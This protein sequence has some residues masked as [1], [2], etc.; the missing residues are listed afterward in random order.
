MPAAA[1]TA[2][3]SLLV[4]QDANLLIDLHCGDLF[5]CVFSLATPWQI[6]IPDLIL[7]ELR[8]GTG[9]V[10]AALLPY[11]DS[12]RFVA[13]TLAGPQVAEVAQLYATQSGL[14]FEDYAAFV[15][16]RE[17]GAVLLT[18]DALLRRFAQTQQVAVHGTLWVLDQLV[19]QWQVL[20][21][22]DGHQALTRMLIPTAG[23]RLPAA[24]CAAR[25]ARWRAAATLG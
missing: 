21:P 22:A 2:V 19:E 4:V 6:H 17:Q 11:Q 23:R 12:G 25:L 15:Y 24:E 7:H 1:T 16:A 8:R 14:S 3:P 13:G 5:E 18:G 9:P 10:A 20:L